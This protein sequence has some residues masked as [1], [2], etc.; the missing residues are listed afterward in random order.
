MWRG[1]G[2]PGWRGWPST[3]ERADLGKLP[4]VDAFVW[5]C[6]GQWRA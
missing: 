6:A 3:D 1:R 2:C 5:R 4:E